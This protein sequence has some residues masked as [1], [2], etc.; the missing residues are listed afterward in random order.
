[1]LLS[2][3]CLLHCPDLP[4]SSSGRASCV[5]SGAPRVDICSAVYLESVSV[6]G[7]RPGSGLGFSCT[8]DHRQAMTVCCSFPV[9]RSPMPCLE[10]GL[11]PL[12]NAVF[13]GDCGWPWH[14]LS[15]F[16]HSLLPQEEL[17]GRAVLHTFQNQLVVPT[18]TSAPGLWSGRTGS[19]EV[20]G[21]RCPLCL[22]LGT[23]VSLGL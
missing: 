8:M 14:L 3:Q 18:G 16:C 17:L 12:P 19:A 4:A 1:M 15:R 5:S 22:S 10:G 11:R 13:P 23:P 21:R 20:L 6:H 7:K 9:G 2:G